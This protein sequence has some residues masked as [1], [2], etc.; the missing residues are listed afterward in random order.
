VQGEWGAA[1]G[2]PAAGATVAGSGSRRLG[3]PAF[4]A[5]FWSVAAGALGNM[6]G[7][8]VN[9]L[10]YFSLRG[11]A[12]TVA[13]VAS[14]LTGALGGRPRWWSRSGGTWAGTAARAW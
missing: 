12:F 6:A 1:A 11:D 3:R 14:L 5:L 13:V 10:S 9:A 2:D 7:A 8:A 4:T